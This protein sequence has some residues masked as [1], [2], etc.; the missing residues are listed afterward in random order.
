MSGKAFAIRQVDRE[1]AE[2][3]RL[4]RQEQRAKQRSRLVVV[5]EDKREEKASERK[6][7]RFAI[8]ETAKQLNHLSPGQRFQQARILF[9]RN[10]R[11]AK[12][13]RLE[14]QKL[15]NNLF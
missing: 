9:D 6:I 4:R 14:Q 8:T 3:A 5:Q 12:L 10:K 1:K 2:A 13:E 7:R 11:E 15:E